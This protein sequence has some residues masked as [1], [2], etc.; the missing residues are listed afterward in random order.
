METTIKK[1]ADKFVLACDVLRSS[2]VYNDVTS[3][4]LSCARNKCTFDRVLMSFDLFRE[5]VAKSG[6]YV[7]YIDGV[8]FMRLKQDQGRIIWDSSTHATTS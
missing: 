5:Q 6:M 3:I 4:L 8:I 2:D 7:N 1:I